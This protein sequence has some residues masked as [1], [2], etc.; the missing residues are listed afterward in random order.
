MTV[1]LDQ[2][3]NKKRKMEVNKAM[4]AQ[5]PTTAHSPSPKGAYETR[6]EPTSGIIKKPE[7]L[8]V[9]SPRTRSSSPY[10]APPRVLK[11][12]DANESEDDSTNSDDEHAPTIS[13]SM[14]KHFQIS[15]QILDLPREEALDLL[16]LVYTDIGKQASNSPTYA[17]TLRLLQDLCYHFC[18]VPSSFLLDKVTFGRS[19]KD[20]VG[21][22]GEATLYCGILL[23][24][25][26][27]RRVV[28]REVSM[29]PWEWKLP[30]GRKVTRLV[31]REAITHSLL[32]H[33]NILPF[34][35]I[36]HEEIDS[37]P[38]TILPLI[39]RGSLQQLLAGPLVSPM[40]LQRILIGITSG[41]VYLHSLQPPIVHGDLHSG[42][43]LIGDDDIPYLCDF[44]LSHIRH[45][46]T[47]TRTIIREGGMR[48]FMAPELSSGSMERFRATTATDIF[49]LAM[50]FLSA[51]SGQPPFSD[52]R[53]D[54]KVVVNLRNGLR[55]TLPTKLVELTRNAKLQL[56]DLLNKMWLPAPGDRPSSADVRTR[57][58][59]FHHIQ[60]AV[61]WIAVPVKR[62][63]RLD[64][65]T[66]RGLQCIE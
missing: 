8:K 6:R 58:M 21:R 63:S 27:S 61:L 38:V 36:Y 12:T 3:S 17:E 9:L 33:P 65:W 14:A 4:A 2:Y 56:W 42:N 37:P 64:M 10:A 1:T 20:I 25:E 41:V 16:D 45:E 23:E 50:T 22:G 43:V 13:L 46:V 48:R 54:T 60:G 40:T 39:E 18:A 29:A 15:N 7:A 52:I 30:V 47:R 19:S 24:G 28:A 5:T 31:H 53:Q 59:P 51:W 49:S 66:K 62:I 26:D 34:L 32:N 57:L 35:G 11:D 55:P 44:G